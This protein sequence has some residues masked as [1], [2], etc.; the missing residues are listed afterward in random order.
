MTN[1]TVA[2]SKTRLILDPDASIVYKETISIADGA[3]LSAFVKNLQRESEEIDTGILPMGTIL[4]RQV[5]TTSTYIIQTEP[6]MVKLDTE[7][8]YFDIFVPSHVVKILLGMRSSGEIYLDTAQCR[9]Y[10]A[11]VP[12]TARNDTL[13]RS[14]MPNIYSYGSICFGNYPT[15]KNKEL[16]NTQFAKLAADYVVYG[17][18]SDHLVDHQLS[19]INFLKLANGVAILDSIKKESNYS[20]RFKKLM[21]MLKDTQPDT[22]NSSTLIPSLTFGSIQ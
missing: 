3:D 7:H 6:K 21:A 4:F 9:S 10:M 18:G 15:L 11:L 1:N 16:S 20:G 8:G 13:Y 19:A 17:K 22:W 2:N 14:F 12:I 5:R